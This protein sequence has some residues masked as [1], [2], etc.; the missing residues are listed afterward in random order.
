M[1]VFA[2]QLLVSFGHKRVGTQGHKDL[3]APSAQDHEN[4]LHENY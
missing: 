2:A 4:G 3:M 1:G